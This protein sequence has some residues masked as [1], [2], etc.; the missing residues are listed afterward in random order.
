MSKR[1]RLGLALVLLSGGLSVLWG[2][3]IGW[4]LPKGPMNFQAVYY[5]SRTLLEH[6]DPYNIS[7]VEAVYRAEGG[8]RQRVNARQHEDMTLY[9]NTPATLLLIA[10]LAMLPMAVGQVLWLILSAGSLIL[11]AFLMW[12][13][14]ADYAP[15][16]SGCLV[17]FLLANCQVIF[18]GGN[19]AGLVVGL[20]VVAAWC[21]LRERFVVAGIVCMAV[22]L[23]INPH[24]TGLVWLFFLLAGGI[25]RKR[26]IQTAALTA[27]LFVPAVIWISVAVPNWIHDWNTNLAIIAAPGG[28]NDPRPAATVQI[29]ADNVISL[30]AVFSV[31]RDSPRF[32][33]WASYLVCGVLLL[34]FVVTEVRTRFSLDRAW[35]ALA[36]VVPLTVLVTYHRLHDTKLLLL[37]VPACAILWAGGGA[38]GQIAAL[39]T[40]AGVVLNSDIPITIF[41]EVIN[42]LHMSTATLSGKIFTVVLARPNQEILL[43]IGIFYLWIYVRRS[44]DARS[45]EEHDGSE[46][47]TSSSSVLSEAGV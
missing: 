36:A 40:T 28:I 16:L 14:G 31:F 21:F 4:A 42:Q 35:F 39:L 10:P 34:I 29:T 18:G 26:A 12:D 46:P 45:G 11:A 24:D 41:G 6:H 27:A 9:V 22:S 43:A 3:S 15:V 8:D 19:T 7:D 23:A 20:T 13:I 47:E 33:N 37:A 38:I 1:R 5:G 30:Q 44:F 17:G 32:Y 25:Y 2:C